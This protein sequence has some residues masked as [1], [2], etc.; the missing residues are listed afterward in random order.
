MPVQ[1]SADESATSTED[2]CAV[3]DAPKS[4]FETSIV[5]AIG[6]LTLGDVNLD[7]RRAGLDE[8][9]SMECFREHPDPLPD[10]D[11]L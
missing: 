8:L 10:A 7:R 5:M 4:D 1:Q 11:N 2:T 3:C 6:E 9:C